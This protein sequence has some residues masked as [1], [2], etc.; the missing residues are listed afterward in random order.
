MLLADPT[1]YDRNTATVF[2]E[3]LV[4]EPIPVVDV[5]TVAR[6]V[7]YVPVPTARLYVQL[8]LK[9]PAPG[10]Y[11]G[12][13]LVT[14]DTQQEGT[15][16]PGIVPVDLG[17]VVPYD[18]ETDQDLTQVAVAAYALHAQAGAGY[19]G[20]AVRGVIRCVGDE[21]RA[22]VRLQTLLAVVTR[23]D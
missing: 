17:L 18:V 21:R 5:E 16:A 4:N 11:T 15:T 22:P 14:P 13:L 6:G 20:F 2:G 10:R 12:R 7:V 8:T 9:Y 23:I 3:R 19:Y 1:L